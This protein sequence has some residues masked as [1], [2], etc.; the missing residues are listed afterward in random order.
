MSLLSR[1]GGTVV[2][3][4]VESQTAFLRVGFQ[5]TEGNTVSLIS[6]L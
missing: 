4:L 6:D 3:L 2:N 5:G 1:L